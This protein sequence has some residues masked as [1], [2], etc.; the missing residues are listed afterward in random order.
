MRDFKSLSQKEGV[1][2]EVGKRLEDLS[3]TFFKLWRGFQEGRL[4]SCEL[5]KETGFTRD[6]IQL[7]LGRSLF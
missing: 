1:L 7:L 6:E 2:G 4:T 5:Q 3:K